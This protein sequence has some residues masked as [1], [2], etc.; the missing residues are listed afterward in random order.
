MRQDEPAVQRYVDGAWR[1][2]VHDARAAIEAMREPTEAM[3]SE[4]CDTLNNEVSWRGKET[5]AAYPCHLRPVWD[6]AIT[7][8]LADPS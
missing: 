1:H 7:A 3:A 4:M 2:F 8:A 6:A 5:E